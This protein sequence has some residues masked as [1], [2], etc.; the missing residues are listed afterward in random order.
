M[1]D[2]CVHEE[3]AFHVMD[4]LV[5]GDDPI[6]ATVRVDGNRVDARVN[7]CK[8]TRPVFA[9]GL[10]AMDVAAFHSVRPFD[11]RVH[12]GD[13]RLN[14]TGVEIAI[15]GGENFAFRHIKVRLGLNYSG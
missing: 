8:L 14:V 13:Y 11:F 1:V 5:Y 10:S 15:C 6:V 12:E 9:N 2:G 7:C 3:V 4:D